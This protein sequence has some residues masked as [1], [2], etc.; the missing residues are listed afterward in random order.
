MVRY[1]HWWGLGRL[2]R[3]VNPPHLHLYPQIMPGITLWLSSVLKIWLFFSNHFL[4]SICDFHPLW[5]H[6]PFFSLPVIY[7]HFVTTFF[8]SLSF[9]LPGM[10]CLGCSL[11]SSSFHKRFLS[12]LLNNLN[13]AYNYGL[14]FQS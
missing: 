1:Y 3:K 2:W 9:I 14:I 6:L 4:V 8:F 12:S 5:H 7:S 10:N 13:E 11:I